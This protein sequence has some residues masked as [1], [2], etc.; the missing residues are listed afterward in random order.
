MLL[1][2]ATVEEIKL[3]EEIDK[4]FPQKSIMKDF[5]RYSVASAA[6]RINMAVEDLKKLS[7][8]GCT[9]INTPIEIV[10]NVWQHEQSLMYMVKLLGGSDRAINLA[11]YHDHTEA[12]VTDFT[13]L[14]NIVKA[15]KTCLE[16]LAAKIIF[17]K[18]PQEYTTWLE[19][20]EKKTSDAVLVGN[21]DKMEF[22]C[23]ALYKEEKYPEMHDVLIEMW[24]DIATKVKIPSLKNVFEKLLAYKNGESNDKSI[25]KEMKP[26]YDK[27]RFGL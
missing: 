4:R 7:R 25:Y 2:F 18:F 15:E 26:Y 20:E 1:D 22:T 14:D 21:V 13:P 11:K 24:D 9:R 10:Q 17:E 8:S 23:Y 27:L 12:I 5:N 3:I 16:R 6:N 19:Y